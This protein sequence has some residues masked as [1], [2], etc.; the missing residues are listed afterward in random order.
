MSQN[1]GAGQYFEY[2]DDTRYGEEA[3]VDGS[4]SGRVSLRLRYTVLAG[5]ALTWVLVFGLLPPH[6]EVSSAPGALVV[7]GD[8]ITYNG[9]PV[10]LRGVAMEDVYDYSSEGRDVATDY[11]RIANNWKANVV[12]ISVHPST[13]R[14][15]KDETLALLREHVD[16]ATNAGLFVIVDYHVIGFPDGYYQSVPPEWGAPPDLYDS[17]FD[18]AKDFWTT[19]S[20]E[21]NDGRV[22]FEL[23][24]EPVDEVELSPSDPNASKWA[25]LKP[26][27]NQLIDIIRGNGNQS[28]ILASGNHWAYNL[29]GI[30]DDLLE[31]SNT[32]YTWHV[33][34]GHDEN[35]PA[36]WAQALDGLEGVRPVLVT[37]WGFKP[38]TNEHFQ[39]TAR[40][41]GNKFR[42]QFLEGRGL[43]STAWCWSPYYSP[44]LLKRGWS[45]RT[46]WGNFAYD[47][48]R[49]Y[50]T[51]PTR[52]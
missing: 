3:A 37:E 45:G 2:G 38:R 43:H 7:D 28:V 32:A 9:S 12:R 5:L 6:E 8:E 36:R 27:F 24:N 52:P 40:T 41:F 35:K 17:D 14:D 46:T 51:N 25:E 4:L 15:H 33:Y 23:W 26:Y 48:L 1:Q 21:I 39:G 13:W 19:V 50:N 20:G 11:A 47:Y 49:T 29:K 22:V 10:R 30:K 44:E 34:A 42:D 16:E 31:D 18:L